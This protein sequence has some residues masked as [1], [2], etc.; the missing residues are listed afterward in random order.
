MIARL[1][2]GLV[3]LSLISIITIFYKIPIAPLGEIVC[4]K[5]YNRL[6]KYNLKNSYNAEPVALADSDIYETA[7]DLM[8]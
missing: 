4:V 3:T 5:T 7:I 1:F 8:E 6:Y 2:G